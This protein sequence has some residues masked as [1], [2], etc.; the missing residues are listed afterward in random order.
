MKKKKK[1]R[2]RG[3]QIASKRCLRASV[4]AAKQSQREEERE[5]GHVGEE[6]QSKKSSPAESAFTV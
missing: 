4:S 3:R 5:G 2:E 1:E 6:R